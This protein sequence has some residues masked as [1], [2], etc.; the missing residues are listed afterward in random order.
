M[1]IVG[2][3]IGSTGDGSSGAVGGDRDSGLVGV[4]EEM[5]RDK[6]S[7]ASWL[8][9]WFAY[10]VGISRVSVWGKSRSCHL[11]EVYRV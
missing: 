3:V 4:G 5:Y 6:W 7:C 8:I 1:Y 9:K 2:G 11:E 10:D